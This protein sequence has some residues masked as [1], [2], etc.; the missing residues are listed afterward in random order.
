[1]SLKPRMSANSWTLAGKLCSVE[2]RL[3]L[4]HDYGKVVFELHFFDGNEVVLGRV[5]SASVGSEREI[6]HYA[7]PVR[8][9]P[10]LLTHAAQILRE[11]IEH[12]ETS[13]QKPGPPTCRL[14]TPEGHRS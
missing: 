11:S 4:T 7:F 8:D 2:N 9:L 12:T 1:M 3:E 5:D 6:R 14:R 13:K 10:S